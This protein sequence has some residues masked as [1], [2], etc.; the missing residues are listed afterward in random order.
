[1]SQVRNWHKV[2]VQSVWRVSGHLIRGLRL[3][4][5]L[6]DK[7]GPGSQVGLM[8]SWVDGCHPQGP[9]KGLCF[10]SWLCSSRA[11][12]PSLAELFLGA[13]RPSCEDQKTATRPTAGRAQQAAW[14][15]E[16][17]SWCCTETKKKKNEM[18][19]G[20]NKVIFF[21]GLV[22]HGDNCGPLGRPLSWH[23]YDI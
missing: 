6:R 8:P 1:M 11:Q 16:D 23:E 12:S 2:S 3:G 13:E 9:D 21:F 20:E 17:S 19:F 22:W 14:G 5:G 15:K 10:F 4:S 18:Q 7:A